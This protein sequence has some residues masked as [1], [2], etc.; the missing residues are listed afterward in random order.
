M[1]TA[2]NGFVGSLATAVQENPVA[3]ALIGGGALWLLLANDKLKAAVGSASAAASSAVD[4]SAQ[5]LHGAA[6]RFQTTSAPPMAPE[7]DTDGSFRVGDAYRRTSAA[8]SGAISE[9]TEKV[10]DRFDGGV[11]F[12][13]ENL[14]RFS[15][16]LPGIEDLSNMQSSLTNLLDRQPLVL[17]AVGLA[18]GAAVAGAFQVSEVENVW[19]GNLSDK[20]KSDMS[21]RAGAVTQSLREA[22]DTLKA[23]LSDTGAEVV[24]RVK[25]AGLDAA[26]AAHA[27]EFAL[28]QL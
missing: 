27:V 24:D 5:N 6:S 12:A 26:D 18:I 16:S 10:R 8:A 25:Q 20:V 21:D 15:E 11:A 4:A 9:A 13:Q 28:D 14:G 1:N 22:S 2:D 17:G 7:Q 3:A 19:V 23:E